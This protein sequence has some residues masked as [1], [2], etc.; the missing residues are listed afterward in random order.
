MKSSSRLARHKP[1]KPSTKHPQLQAKPSTKAVVKSGFFMPRLALIALCLLLAGG[2]TWAAFEF[3]I[4]AKLPSELVGKW[5]V[6]GGKQDGA[7][8]DFSRGGKM[9]ARLNHNGQEALINATVVVEGDILHVTTPHP[10]TKVEDTRKI[11]ILELT[12]RR[13]TLQDENGELWK[14]D[15]AN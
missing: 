5:V 13:L 8:F 9:V 1:A 4:L 15:R 12:E 11:K 14:M 7:T 10:Q 3:V 2:A 6:V